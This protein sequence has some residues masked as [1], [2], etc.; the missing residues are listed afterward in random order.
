MLL[1]FINCP[2]KFLASIGL[3]KFQKFR[4][5]EFPN[6]HFLFIIFY[7]WHGSISQR[8]WDCSF[9][10]H[11]SSFSVLNIIETW[12]IRFLNTISSSKNTL[13]YMVKVVKTCWEPRHLWCRYKWNFSA[14]LLKILYKI[15][16]L[17][18]GGLRSE[19]C[20]K[21]H[22]IVLTFCFIWLWVYPCQV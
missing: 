14:N 20:K 7:P 21:V 4:I 8:I 19:I 3:V 9:S 1:E 17:W 6:T 5:T 12:M 15:L 11:L 13:S 10:N 22:W 16:D 2:V 18:C